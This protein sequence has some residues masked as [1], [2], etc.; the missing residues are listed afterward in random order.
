LHQ[1]SVQVQQQKKEIDYYLNLPRDQ[2]PKFEE[3]LVWWQSRMVR[4]NLPCLTQVAGAILACH[5]SSGGLECNFGLL[6][7]VVKARR[8]SLGQGFVEIRPEPIEED[9]SALDESDDDDLL[10]LSGGSSNPR[11]PTVELEQNH[12]PISVDHVSSE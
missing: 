8:A 4:E 11:V 2:W 6:K 10:D 12:I 5:P 3:T 9:E 7:D 1:L